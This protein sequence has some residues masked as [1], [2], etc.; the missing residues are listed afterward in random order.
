MDKASQLSFSTAKQ[1]E[2]SF[3]VI[4]GAILAATT[5]AV[6]FGLAM[7]ESAIKSGAELEKMSKITGASVEGLQV[8]KKAA[9]GV[10]VEFEGV[11]KGMTKL[12]KAMVASNPADQADTFTR[13]GLSVRDASGQFKASDTMMLEV[14]GRLSQ[15]SDGTERAALA[16]KLM[17]KAGA[18]NIPVLLRLASSYQSIKDQMIAQGTMFSAS[19]TKAAED[20][21]RQLKQLSATGS[22]V[23]IILAKEFL[24]ILTAVADA[25][26]ENQKNSGLVQDIAVTLATTFKVLGS[27]ALGVIETFT[28]WGINI[29]GL[30]ATFYSLLPAIE[31]VG[32]AMTGDFAGAAAMVPEA[33]AGIENIGDIWEDVDRQILASATKTNLAMNKLWG[34]G[35]YGVH[36]ELTTKGGNPED[37]NKK[38][39]EKAIE[40]MI[41]KLREQVETFGQSAA[42]IELYKAKT[43]GAN[44]SQLA[45]I[46]TLS[47]QLAIMKE[48]QG[49]A[50]LIA[51]V[52]KQT[53]DLGKDAMQ[54]EMEKLKNEEAWH[55]LQMERLRTALLENQAKKDAIA[56]E[57]ELKTVTDAL[58]AAQLTTL[59]QATLG[60]AAYDAWTAKMVAADQA[61][62][63]QAAAVRAG[64]ITPMEELT[65]RIES[66][67]VLLDANKI[68]WETYWA[69][70]GQAQHKYEQEMDKLNPQS[71]EFIQ[72]MN[73]LAKSVADGFTNAIVNGKG[74]SG[75]L[76]GLVKDLAKLAIQAKITQPLLAWL[77]GGGGSGLI[78]G[79]GHIFGFAEGG[80]Y[81]AGVPRIVGENGPELDIPSHSGTIVPN[82]GVLRGGGGNT[83]YLDARGTDAA[84]VYMNVARAIAQSSQS[85][86]LGSIMAT[87][88]IQLRR[89]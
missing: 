46:S 55:P 85:T 28:E 17:G 52:Q 73:L 71:K 56:A 5:A 23:G 16:Q 1:I 34:T 76:Q 81:A 50:A 32:M 30:G 49:N 35:D 62:N 57:A 80:D 20:F 11:E 38:N 26:L 67:G 79:I 4:S 60:T 39:K 21:E 88:E 7:M 10:G 72:N 6:G 64:L 19:D 86:A 40:S 53:N 15:M 3:K 65:A 13:L 43:D 44:A 27:V 54:L 89:A 36:L 47:K 8:L 33:R 31:A 82:G 48:S 63:Q 75:V 87:A 84:T 77:K 14:A 41:A 29:K 25:M 42:A 66:L 69:A 37:V 9:A 61:L 58:N 83:I 18:E 68:S 59:S 22:K 51:S 74:F 12:A 45:L 78:A 24:P 70:I 2:K